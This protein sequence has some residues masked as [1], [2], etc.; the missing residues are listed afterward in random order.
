MSILILAGIKG[1]LII[2]TAQDLPNYEKHFGDGSHLGIKVQYQIQPSPDG[3]AQAFLKYKLPLSDSIIYA[4]T[5]GFETTL[6]T[7]DNDFDDLDRVR[8]LPKVS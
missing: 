5:I 1:I 3:L 6:W 4:T 2:T 7:Q 8:F